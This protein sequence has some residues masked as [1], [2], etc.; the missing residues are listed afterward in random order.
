M[1]SKLKISYLLLGFQHLLAMWGA[2][3]LVPLLT[4]LDPSVALL[5]AGI[6]TVIF[7]IATGNKVPVFLGSSFAFIGAIGLT[8][9]EHGLAEV[10]GG[11]MTAGLIYCFLSLLIIRIG[12][13]KTMNL[14]PPIVTGPII[15]VIGLRLAPV[16]TGMV[17]SNGLTLTNGVITAVTLAT[18]LGIGVFTK[19]FI[20]KLSIVAAIF[21]GYFVASVFKIIDFTP[22]IEAS[23][24]GY[25]EG[26]MTAL[27]TRPVFSATSV[28]AIAPIALVTFIEHI[29]DI[30]TNGAVVNKNFIKN[31]GLHMTILGDG[32]ATFVAGMLGAPANTTYSE[33]T[34]VLATTKSYEPTILLIAAIFSIILSAIGKFG[35]ILS[36]IPPSIIGVVSIILFGTISSIGIKTLNN[37]KIDFSE[38]KNIFI[39]SIILVIGIGISEISFCG[40]GVSGLTLAAV[41]GVTLNLLLKTNS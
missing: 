24:F 26:S 20:Q 33:N 12:S 8:L 17:L 11:I 41:V 10:K 4:G 22:I 14:F 36:S 37:A 18:L 30:V 28:L 23:W 34:G 35:A 9:Q 5:G 40:I 3:V 29:G 6:G 39:V 32:L 19:G 13:E 1:L 16:A 2:T 7:H 38:N 15:I 21:V 31:P 27:M 25:G